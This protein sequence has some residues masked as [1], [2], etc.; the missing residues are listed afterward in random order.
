[1]EQ[2]RADYFVEMKCKACTASTKDGD[3]LRD[4]IDNKKAEGV[5]TPALIKEMQETY[6]LTFNQSNLDGHFKR[7]S[8]WILGQKKEI[9]EARAK[10]FLDRRKLRHRTAEEE[11]QKL[12]DVGGERIDAGEITVDKDLYM[13]ALDRKMRK[14]EPISIQNLVMNFGDALE[15]A[16]QKRSK[17]PREQIKVVENE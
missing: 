14:E 8:R 2:I 5:S 3:S 1:M 10:N 11:I 17:I 6:G 16:H 15:E 12:I 9:Q 13:F 4:L 7:H